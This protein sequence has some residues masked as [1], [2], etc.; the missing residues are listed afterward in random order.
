MNFYTTY[1]NTS[2]LFLFYWPYLLYVACIPY[3]NVC[4]HN[5][6]ENRSS[7]LIHNLNADLLLS[8]LLQSSINR[9]ESCLRAKCFVLSVAGDSA[10]EAANQSFVLICGLITSRAVSLLSPQVTEY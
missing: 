3:R 1:N 6:N 7:E 10:Q 4:C 9:T 8:T 5:L 2:L